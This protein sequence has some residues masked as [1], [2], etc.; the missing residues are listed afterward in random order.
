ANDGTC[1]GGLY[2]NGSVTWAEANTNPGNVETPIGVGKPTTGTWHSI[3]YEYDRGN[4]ADAT[5]GVRVR[6]WYD[7]APTVSGSPTGSSAFWG[8]DD[9]APDVGGPW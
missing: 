8:R 5:K 4:W 1:K 9:G 7:G 3:E 6:F 2:L